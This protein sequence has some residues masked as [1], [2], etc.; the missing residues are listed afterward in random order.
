[1]QKQASIDIE[2]FCLLDDV[3]VLAAMKHWCLHEDK[4]LSVLCKGIIHRQLLKIKFFPEPVSEA[5]VKEKRAE[6]MKKFSISEEEAGWLVFTGEATN[7]IYNFEDENIRI[8]FKDGSVKDISEVDN[9]LISPNIKGKIKKY[10][11][12]YPR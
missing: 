9:A 5:L 6:A 7:S 8:L 1:M 10:Y 4:P 12:C 11:I 2:K 3:D